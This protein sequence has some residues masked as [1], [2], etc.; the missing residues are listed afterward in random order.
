VR[1][2]RFSTNVRTIASRSTFLE[3]CRRVEEQGYQLLFAADHLGIPAPFSTV[4]TAAAATERLRVGTLVLN[5][6]FWNPALLAREIATADLLTDGRLEVGLGSGHM[7]W[8]F[9]QAGI[10]WRPFAERAR[11][12]GAMIE[13]LNRHFTTRLDG[14]PS[15]ASA[16]RPVQRL[17]FAGSGP[18][19]LIGGTGDRVLELAAA[20]ATTVGVAGMFQRPDEPPGTF[21]LATATEA[22]ER[23][24]FVR[25]RA[26][27]RAG[28]LEW[29]L[30]VQAVVV[31]DDR[32]A[33]ARQLLDQFGPSLQMSPDEVLET[34]FLLIGTAREMADQLRAERDRYGF[35]VITVHEPDQ[36]VFAPVIERLRSG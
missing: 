32:E 1:E 36:E 12:L 26:G 15:G 21:R 22:E 33:A 28:D 9:D 3:R 7:K 5:S 8:E 14:L 18:P 34:P 24:R 35:S 29:Q 25:E 4:V 23:V 30:L 2:F 6:E 20:H 13:E 19:L 31:T 27:S 16:L 11:R 17:G 10:A